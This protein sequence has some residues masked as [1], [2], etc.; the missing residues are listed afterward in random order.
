MPDQGFFFA[1][2]FYEFFSKKGCLIVISSVR[3][4]SDEKLR[5][6]GI[7]SLILILER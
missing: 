5:L 6:G 7:R 4:F 1:H 2:Q 3:Y